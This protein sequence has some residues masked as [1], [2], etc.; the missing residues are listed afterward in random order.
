MIIG[1]AGKKR[2]G[3]TTSANYL[4]DLYN[5]DKYSFAQPIKEV[6]SLLFGWDDVTLTEYKEQVCPVW[7]IKPREFLQWFGTDVMRI[8]AVKQFPKFKAAGNFWVDKMVDNFK[9]YSRSLTIDDVRFQNEVDAIHNLGGVV[10]Q[11]NRTTGHSDNHPS[12]NQTLQGIN[13]V[14]E[15][16]ET[17]ETLHKRISEVMEVEQDRLFTISEQS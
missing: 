14:I 15:N 1:F 12:E 3:K 4:V 5:F 9:N 17:I 16:N 7:G 6:A 11:I 10:V 13:Y 8:D 2:V